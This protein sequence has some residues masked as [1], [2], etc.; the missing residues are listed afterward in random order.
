MDFSARG[1]AGFAAGV[2]LRAAGIGALAFAALYL[3]QSRQLYATALV[4]LGLAL[5]VGLDLARSIGAADRLMAQFVDGLLAEGYERPTGGGAG[6]RRLDAAIARALATLDRTRAER[7]R[8]ID[9]LQALVDNVQAA[10]L[11]L[12]PAGHVEF[13]NRAARRRLGEASGPLAALP[14]LGPAAGL[15]ASAAPGSREIVTLGDG[16]RMLASTAGFAA[17]GGVRRLIALQSLAGDLDA[18]ELNAWHDLVRILSHEMMNSLTPICSL[19][20]SLAA[21]AADPEAAEALE[22][23]ARRG[24]GLMSFV[25]RYRRLADLPPAAKVRVPL[26]EL[27]GRV[28]R[29]MSPQMRAAGVAYAVA[30]P[31]AGLAVQADPDLLEQALINLLKNGLEAA[32]GSPGAA[33][34]LSC[35]DAGE[36]VAIVIED[37]GPGLTPHDLERAFTPFFTTKPGGSGVGLS[38][39]RQIALAHRGRLDYAPGRPGARF[40]L[41][42][43]K[44]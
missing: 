43:A 3:A 24:E 6:V 42:L 30:A 20:E 19:A 44:D 37:T 1:P 34:R 10:V 11:V 33:V 31:E 18:V 8:R 38:L 15:L 25:D 9:Y 17:E 26:S 41:T 13:A 27:V 12:D 28:D 36:A 39:A 14:A 40:T 7:Q 35:A 32:R 5:L 21:R 2:T 29:L 22:V 4:L 16:A 23:I